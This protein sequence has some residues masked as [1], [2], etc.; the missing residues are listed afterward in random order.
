MKLIIDNSQELSSYVVEEL[1]ES[2][3]KSEKNY[4][5]QGIFSTAGEKNR[6]GRIY[7]KPLWEREISDF[8][9]KIKD[10]HINLLGEW[11]HPPRSTV[12]PM[13]AVIKIVEVKMDGNYV[14]GKAKILNNNSPETNQIK[15]LIDEGFKIG[16]SSRGVGRLGTS[17]IVEEFKLITWDLVTSPSNFGSNLNGMVESEG[18]LFLEGIL[19]DEDFMICNESGCVLNK[20]L[21]DTILKKKEEKKEMTA[22]YKAKMN[23]AI[24]SKFKEILNTK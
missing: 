22:D 24:I 3:G 17:A 16:I 7:P 15:S 12:D 11:E 21:G 1:N 23:E 18:K 14:M 13:K 20:H 9:Q 4:Y 2:S 8:Q 10:N 6:N 19:E 5:V